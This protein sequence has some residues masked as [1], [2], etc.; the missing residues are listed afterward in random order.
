MVW[1]SQSLGND[2]TLKDT[3]HDAGAKL[4]GIL[5]G[6]QLF[7][8]QDNP[9]ERQPGHAAMGRRVVGRRELAEL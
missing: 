6:F 2:Q 8:G 5:V 1:S 4:K 3:E 7:L 9:A